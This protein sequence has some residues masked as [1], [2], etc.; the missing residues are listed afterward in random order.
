MSDRLIV[1]LTALDL[2]YTAIRALMTEVKPH[3]HRH[4]TR[5]EVGRF[6]GTKCRVALAL[7]G[8][9]NQSSATLAERSMNEFNPLAVIF[10]GVAG[11][12]RSDIQLGDV[13][14]A[15]HV[16]AY[17]GATSEDDGTRTRPRVW[18]ASHGI[19]QLAHYV[20]RTAAWDRGLSG[21]P[22]VRFG[23]MAA[24]EV[25]LNSRTSSEARLLKERFNDAMAIEMEAAGVA[26]AAHLNSA[27][28]VAVVRGISD[29]ADGTKET[30]DGEQWQP[31]AVANAAA[32]A[33]AL[34]DELSRHATEN[35]DSKGSPDMT[36]S[37]QF[38]NYDNVR[39]GV[40]AE[41]F[42][43]TFVQGTGGDDAEILIHKISALSHLIEQAH[44][45]KRLDD[46]TC[47]AARA[48]LDAAVRSRDVTTKNG[49]SRMVLALK[50]L[51][52]LVSDVTDLAAKVTALIIDV[53]ARS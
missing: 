40:Q 28:P 9:G 26:Q 15:S 49:A 27:M 4:G 12:L 10:V 3:L 48:E 33:L 38:N 47:E 8:K 20:A 36:R 7:V 37:V 31:R 43:G 25:V 42:T 6:E 32:F 22:R 51:L 39:V 11:A 18:E 46:A 34:A 2:E 16:Y 35:P 23:P 5:F 13:V 30:T 19:D 50:R 14:V 41:T 44:A 1:I 53:K 52:G 24:G 21:S 45:D 17:H 29:R